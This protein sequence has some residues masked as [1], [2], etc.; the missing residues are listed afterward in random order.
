[1]ED[2]PQ[3]RKI[4]RIDA[5]GVKADLPLAQRMRK[6]IAD[7][8]RRQQASFPGAQPVSFTRNHLEELRQKE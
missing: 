2:S 8:L 3:S 1:M 5:P 4:Q 7:L 6:E